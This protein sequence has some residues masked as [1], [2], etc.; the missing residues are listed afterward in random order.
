MEGGAT[1]G[2]VEHVLDTLR[3]PLAAEAAAP[4]PQLVVPKLVPSPKASPLP[5][6]AHMLHNL[7]RGVLA[8]ATEAAATQ[9][10]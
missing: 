6:N 2:S 10:Q 3:C 7:V 1:T 9:Q 8:A 4:A 5:L